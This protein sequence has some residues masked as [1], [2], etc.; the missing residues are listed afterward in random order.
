MFVPRQPEI[1]G[2]KIPAR[3]KSRLGYAIK[4]TNFHAF[5]AAVDEAAG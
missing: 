2:M 3:H 4:Q 5:T 1:V